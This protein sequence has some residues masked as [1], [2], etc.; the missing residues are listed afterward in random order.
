MKKKFPVG[1]LTLALVLAC[2]GCSAP[3]FG[4]ESGSNGAPASPGDPVW[5]ELFAE[6]DRE[7]GGNY[8]YGSVV[9]Q[10]FK[11]AEK[12]PSSYF[13]LD[14]NTANYAQVRT[15][16]K[17]NRKIAP[18][19]VRI[20]ELVNYF[21]Y[22]GY[23]MPADGEEI[24][25]TPSVMVCPWNDRHLLASVGIRTE[26]RVL[27]SD[28]N[29]YTFLIDTSGSMSWDIDYSEGTTSRL[30][31]VKHGIETMLGGFGE[32]DRIS[33]VTYAGSVKT[34]LEPTLATPEGKP[35]IMRALADLTS[36]GSTNG[37]GGLERA[38][39]LAEANFAPAGN[40]RV[41]LMTDGDFNVGMHNADELEAY[42]RGKAESGVYL[43][44]VGVGL[45]NM[46]DDIME[47]L[48]L[49]GNGNYAYIDS[50]LEAEKVLSEELAGTLFTVAKD[51]KAGVT[52]D[53]ERVA[54]YRMIGYDR[55]VL[56][57]ED[58]NDPGKDAG[59]IGSDLAATIL[60]EIVPTENDGTMS[61]EE[62]LKNSEAPF[63]EVE[64][65]YRRAQDE[66][67]RS[68]K[69]EIGPSNP[70]SEDGIFA[71]CVAEFGL[72]LRQSEYGGTAALSDV[73]ARLEALGEPVMRDP[74][75]REFYELVGMAEKSGYY[76]RT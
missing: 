62:L 70:S 15:Q 33:V 39:E 71:A 63:A 35:K 30:D 43:S 29:N 61:A 76:G 69:T 23:T 20:E 34:V 19:S 65:R 22:D 52:F 25:L 40:N 68:V 60:Y 10:G 17:G 37:A 36:G 9:E 18:D 44:V 41:I 57:E 42:I 54:E 16:I 13:S 47:T 8:V 72:V 32:T 74:F 31:L 75:K 46:R 28:C 55:K 53:P 21:S 27:E 73:L 64:I 4:G 48:A 6:G 12:E 24:A 11:D 50:A 1:T 66:A 7:T 2:A 5:D 56:S 58:F 51:V 26:K 14:R 38:Y 67:A 3:D 49:A 45:G 59:E